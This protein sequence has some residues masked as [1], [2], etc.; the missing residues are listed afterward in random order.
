MASRKPFIAVVDDD[1]G[2]LK[3]VSEALEMEEYQAITAGDGNRGLQLVQDREPNLVLLD[4]TMP[5]LDGFQ[6]CERIRD[7]SSV[8]VIM[9]TAKGRTEDVVRALDTGAD[10]YITK[11]FSINELLA[12]VKA[13]LRR[14]KFPEEM[15]QRPFICEELCIDFARHRVT[16]AGEEIALSPTEYRILCLLAVNAGKVLTQDHLLAEVWGTEHNGHA[17]TLRVAVARLRKKLGDDPRNL[18]FIL[19]RP[20]MGYTLREPQ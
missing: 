11:P 20:G 6:V 2:L 7:F 3:L 18:R 16:V 13:V 19:T 4:I 1:P 9:L 15:P 8:P 17:H 5:G 12:R 14:T 10:D